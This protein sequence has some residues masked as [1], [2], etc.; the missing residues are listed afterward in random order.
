MIIFRNR[1]SERVKEMKS[2]FTL[3]ILI[4]V[5]SSIF[6]Q[7]GNNAFHPMTAPGA[8]GVTT[9]GHI[10]Y[11]ENPGNGEEF[12]QVYFSDDSSL[13]ANLDPSVM[14]LSGEPSTV[15][16]SVQI[17]NVLPGNTKFYWS[18]VEWYLIGD[19]ITRGS[20]IP[21]WYF[22]TDPGVNYDFYD[23]TNDLEGWQAMGPQGTAN[24]YWSNTA[25]TSSYPGEA[26][27]S[28]SPAFTGTS[29]LISPE[30]PEPA[31]LDMGYE[32]QY[33][34][35]FNSD[36]ATVGM[37]LTTD[38][39]VTWDSLW[40]VNATGN[41]GPTNGWSEFTTE[42]N[43]R[44]GF[45]YKGNSASIN[46]FY[47]DE[48]WAILPLTIPAG[49]PSQLEARASKTVK[50]VVLNWNAGWAI[51][52]ISGYW[53]QRQDGL[54]EDNNPYTTIG[55]TGASTRTFI[56][57][58]VILDQNY[59]YRVSTFT[60]GYHSYYCN[61]A[62]AYVPP[63]TPVE[64]VSFN[65]RAE[66]DKVKLNWATATE[67]NNSGFEVERQSAGSTGQRGKD[68]QAIGFV[69]G[70]GTSVHPHSYSF[71]DELSGTDLTGE[72]S[73][74]Y[75]L[76]QIDFDGSYHYSGIAEVNFYAP[77]SY[78]LEQNYPNPFNPST[79][80][81]FALP[82]D[83]GVKITVFNALGQ[84]VVKLVD[85]RFTAGSHRVNFDASKL[86]SGLYFYTL[87]AKGVDGSA[88]MMAKKM[89]LMK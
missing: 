25:H 64:L 4:A 62:T 5:S 27:F 22:Y 33:Y 73:Y 72:R 12:N 26:V 43:F 77:L 48:V 6:P 42:G 37:G 41:I 70:A 56:D 53:I 52:P 76:K 84:E 38:N 85:N 83:A 36:T 68:W 32:F 87:E 47:V 46:Y 24:W 75:R 16:D 67:T 9:T 8:I 14:I 88:Y 61:E 44:I 40:E 60:G 86:S 50:Q 89:V 63:V 74:A 66:G 39:G 57:T 55:Q 19:N 78:S 18:V 1:I 21:V 81:S 34:L 49:P 11:W 82:V 7:S 65:A 28:G 35:D 79:E 71:T 54:P 20:D 58:A 10:L 3:L 2:L 31:G 15:Y 51:D 17:S 29:Y 45:F 69:Q 13:V 80:I 23:F 59:T 30:I